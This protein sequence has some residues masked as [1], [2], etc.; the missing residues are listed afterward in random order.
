MFRLH[1][2]PDRWWRERSGRRQLVY[3]HY[4]VDAQGSYKI[5]HSFSVY[6]Y[7]LNL[8]NEVFGLYNGSPQYVVQRE[9]YKPTY[10]GGVRYTFSHEK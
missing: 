10:A 4:Q 7:R 9:Y 2:R 3:T 8:N 6:A 1:R 5:S